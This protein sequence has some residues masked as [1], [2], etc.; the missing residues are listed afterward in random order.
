[1]HPFWGLEIIWPWHPRTARTLDFHPPSHHHFRRGLASPL[2]SSETLVSHLEAESLGRIQTSWRRWRDPLRLMI[3]RAWVHPHHLFLPPAV[4][5][6]QVQHVAAAAPATAAES[7]HGDLSSD[8][9]CE[10]AGGW[11]EIWPSPGCLARSSYP[12]SP[13]RAGQRQGENP[14]IQPGAES[15]AWPVASVFL[16]VLKPECTLLGWANNV[17]IYS[18][19]PMPLVSPIETPWKSRP[20]GERSRRCR[21]QPRL[22]ASETW[23]PPNATTSSAAASPD[24]SSKR[25][26][27]TFHFGGLSSPLTSLTKKIRNINKP[28][29]LI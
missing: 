17:Q 22:R 4:A 14:R 16:K 11:A 1:M 3:Q 7:V 25:H 2:E 23:H 5:L 8:V 26:P 10:I 27:L 28:E 9:S 21:L 19:P 29:Y 20:V 24:Q 12:I 15:F 18:N 6:H 13:T